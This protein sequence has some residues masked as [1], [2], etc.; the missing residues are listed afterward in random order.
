MNAPVRQPPR[1][2]NVASVSP[3]N[4]P[5]PLILTP[6]CNGSLPERIVACAGSVSGTGD[7]ALR[8][9]TDSRASLCSVGVFAPTRSAR[10]VSSVMS[11]TLYFCGSR[12]A[13]V[14]TQKRNERR[15]APHHFR[16]LK[17]DVPMLLGGILVALVPRH[18][19]GGDQFAARESRLDDLVHVSALRGDVRVRELCVE[20]VNSR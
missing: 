2:N 15:T 7:S 4:V 6:W 1:E 19:E 18:R 20:L 16:V 12:F 17:R 13:H 5:A 14:R 3:V 10:N 8:N 9:A 11:R